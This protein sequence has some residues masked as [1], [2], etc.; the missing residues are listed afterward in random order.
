MALLLLLCLFAARSVLARAPEAMRTVRLRHRETQRT[1]RARDVAALSDLA[2]SC[3]VDLDSAS[4]PR[5]GL[6][7][8][9]YLA[10]GGMGWVAR[11]AIGSTESIW[12]R[13]LASDPNIPAPPGLT[14]ADNLLRQDFFV[15][16]MRGDNARVSEI[17]KTISSPKWKDEAQKAK[18]S[19]HEEAV[20]R[21]AKGMEFTHEE[22]LAGLA[23]W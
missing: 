16:L 15:A 1:L 9:K 6:T 17:E 11:A 23:I 4:F 3:G 5:E 8:E 19:N 10:A 7:E 12:K 20:R 13:P 2:D 14:P 21:F 22:W 18:E